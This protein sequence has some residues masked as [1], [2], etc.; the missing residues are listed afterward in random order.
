MVL[1]SGVIHMVE[2]YLEQVDAL[3]YGWHPGTM[4]GS[5]YVDLL[6]GMESPSGKLPMTF[7]RTEGQIPIYYNHTNSGHPATDDTWVRMYDIPIRAWQTSLGNTNHYL[8]YGLE[9]LFEFGFGLSYTSFV[10]SD[11]QVS[12]ETISIQDSIVVSANLKN[13][14]GYKAEDVAQLY[15]RDLVGSIVRPV[16]ELKGFKRVMLNPGEERRI[17]FMLNPL[18]FEFYN[19]KEWVIEPGKFEVWIGNSSKAQLKASFTLK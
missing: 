19:G 14:G 16:K 4:G 17:D 11:I 5:G 15:I 18:D 7:P 3:L 1:M 9:P 2:P 8:D 13:T 12:K 10:Y 6:F